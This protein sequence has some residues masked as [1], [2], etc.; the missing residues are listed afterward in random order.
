[1]AT[2]NGKRAPIFSDPPPRREQWQLSRQA[3]EQPAG[4][5]RDRGR[6]G[7]LDACQWSP[8]VLACEGVGWMNK[9]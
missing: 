5:R 7:Q 1:M 2:L 4:L 6:F 3:F 8:W 9:L